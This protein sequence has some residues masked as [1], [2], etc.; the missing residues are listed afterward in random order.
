MN[1]TLRQYFV[2]LKNAG[3]VKDY[4][5]YGREELAVKNMTYDSKRPVEG[6]IF[7]CKGQNFK[8]EYLQDA[9]MR[10]AVCYVSEND[11]ELEGQVP[12]ILVKDIRKAMPILG[13][14]FYGEPSKELSLIGITGTKGKTTTAHYIQ[15]IFNEYLDDCGEKGIGLFSSVTTYDGVEKTPSLMTT[16]ESLELQRHFRNAADSG[17]RYVAMEV[18]SQA[19]KYHRVDNLT[20]DVGVFLHISEDHISPC[21]HED[22]EDYFSSKLSI[23]KQTKTACVNTDSANADRIVKAARLAHETVTFGTTGNPDIYGYNIQTHNGQISFHVK[24]DRFN[25]T[26]RLAMHGLFNIEN[27]L[28]AIATAY[29]YKIPVKYMVAGLANVKVDGRMEQYT[30]EEERITAIVDYAHNRLSFE[31][32]F[33][34]VLIEYPGYK[35]VSVFGCPGGKAYNRRRDLGLIAGLFSKQVYLVA[36]DPG[37]ENARAIADEIGKYMDIVG[38]PYEFVDDRGEA[39]RRAIAEA[40]EN[41][42]V[43]VLGKGN[44]GHQKYGDL[45]YPYPSDSEFVKQGIGQRKKN[46]RVQVA[47]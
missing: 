22:F 30:C 15:A 19:L 20:Y 13:N 25:K 37:T 33:D 47:L 26:F 43:L 7:I 21:E 44:E 42:V 38:C 17:L 31:R 23:F 35:I 2:L 10:G 41:T 24:C 29:V 3:L 46:V 34:S 36:D 12:Y 28:A 9:V 32:L 11:Y 14:F 27:A 6:G 8:K 4:E 40:D 18:S 45:T 16:P 1:H 5:L 39:I